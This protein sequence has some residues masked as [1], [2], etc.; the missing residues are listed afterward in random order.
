MNELSVQ[1]Q[2]TILSLLRLGWSRRRIARETGHRRETITR[3]GVAAGLLAPT[4]IADSKP[5]S[6]AEV[7]TDSKSAGE[8]EVPP[9][10]K[11]A[12]EAEVPADPKSAG[13]AEVPSGSA[14]ATP[15]KSRSSCEGHRPFITAE[16]TKGRNGT[17]IFQDL[18]EH[19]GYEGS[20]DAVKRFV[21]TLVPS[22]QKFS[23]RFETLPGQDYV[24][25]RVM[26]SPT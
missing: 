26:L 5:A 11:S 4:P 21:R 19:H 20:Y 9:D 14:A 22:T 10:P 25:F 23:C 6:E 1:E 18:V 13:E 8:A 12:G 17:A 3:Y 15:A 2:E 16:I 7:P 24:E